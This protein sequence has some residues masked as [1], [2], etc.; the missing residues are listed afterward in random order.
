[1]FCVPEA[2]RWYPNLPVELWLDFA[3][4]VPEILAQTIESTPT[5]CV[6][7]LQEWH[8]SY[9]SLGDPVLQPVPEAEATER[10]M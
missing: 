9:S 1:M 8:D 6:V 2:R 3:T 4:P 5:T 7:P 10:E